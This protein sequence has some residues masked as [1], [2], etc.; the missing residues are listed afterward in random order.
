LTQATTRALKQHRIPFFAP[1]IGEDEVQSVV[2]TLRSGWLTTGPKV[3]RFE[4]GFAERVGSRHAIAVNSAT[5]A[6]HLALEAVGVSSG[7]EVLVP[8]MTF[9]STAEVVLHLGAKPVLV[10]CRPDTLCIDAG[11]IEEKTTARTKAIVP[12]HYG[13]QP[14]DMD[15][16]LAVADPHHLKVIEDAAHALPAR[17]GDRVVGTIG[18]V[19]C[20]SFYA[21]KTITTGEGGMIT[22]EDDRLAERMRIMSLHGIS[23]DAWKRFSAEGSWYY[24]IL[25]PGYKFNMTDVAASLGIHQLAKCD[26]FWEGRRR[27]AE[28]YDAGFADVDEVTVPHVEL[29]VQHAWHLYVVQL[30]LDRLRIDRN[31]FI[32]ELNQA[33]VGTSVHYTPLHMH[34][35]YRETFGYQP[36]DLPVAK[37]VYERIISL[38]IYPTL[39]HA[40]AQYVVDTVKRIVAANRRAVSAQV[41]LA[42]DKSPVAQASC[43]SAL[44]SEEAQVAGTGPVPSAPLRHPARA[45]CLGGKDGLGFQPE[46]EARKQDGCPTVPTRGAQPVVKRAFDFV[47]ALLGLAILSPLFLITAAL[48]KLTSPGPVFFR[49]A[50]MGRGFRPF[51]IFKFRTMVRDADARGSQ[52]TAG[53]D[54]RITRIGHVLRKTKIDELPQLINVLKGEMSFVGPRPEVPQYVE[55]FRTD[56]EQLLTVRPGI[57]DLASLKYRHESEILGRSAEPEKTYVNEVLP[58]KIALAK[59]YLRSCSLWFDLRLILKTLLRL[60]A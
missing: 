2:E 20:F 13:G 11:R 23:K 16:V 24:E 12:V 15:R 27:C 44:K 25:A 42:P 19:T 31:T 3:K 48:V 1:S 50:R 10:D 52:L 55:M 47:G 57:T 36:E 18:D 59:E 4:E 7:D 39:S 56:Y 60:A 17:Y 58:E 37:A 30:Q 34:P 26:R 14:C 49:Q 40:D 35:Y 46:G 41:R 29:N 5:S 22:T 28:L 9:A 6:L 43:P 38:P 33:G 21:N 8:T 32:R 54:P 51:K 45:D 53:K